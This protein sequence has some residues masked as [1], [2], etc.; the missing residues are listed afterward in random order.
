MKISSP[1][2]TKELL[3][4]HGFSFKKSFG[5]N[6]LIDG[7]VL[8][9]IVSEADITEDTLVIEIG[10]GIGAL[11]QYLADVSKKVLA[12]EI[13]TRLEPLLA[14]TLEEYPNVEVV[15]EDFLKADVKK[16]IEEQGE[17]KDVAVVANLPYYITTPIITKILELKMPVNRMVFMMQ[18]EVAK[19]LSANT[20]TKDYNSLSIFI[21]YYCSARIVLDISRTVFIPQPNVDSAILRLDVLD[22]PSVN[23]VDEDRMFTMIRD[24]FKMRRKTLRN[25]YKKYDLELLEKVFAKNGLD[26]TLRAE[27]LTLQDYANIVNTL[28]EFETNM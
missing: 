27:A 12:F 11:T 25:N 20:S 18:K 28:V 13:D 22:T 1:S 4:R 10:P 14:E 15:F 7:N 2:K 17:F 24:G 3:K 9:N 21:Q 19:R 5:Q 26:L 23:V 16:I 6:F 8:S